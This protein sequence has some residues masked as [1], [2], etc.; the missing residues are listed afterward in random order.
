MAGISTITITSRRSEED[1]DAET[2]P[3][4]MSSSVE[5]DTEED[6]NE[7]ATRVVPISKPSLAK[8][9]EEPVKIR[10]HRLQQLA[11]SSAPK[12]DPV[13]EEPVTIPSHRLQ[14]L[15]PPN[16][17]QTLHTSECSE[18]FSQSTQ[19]QIE[20]A[21]ARGWWCH[22]ELPLQQL[23]LQ[24][25]AKSGTLTNLEYLKL[26]SYEIDLGELELA[27][28]VE[29]DLKMRQRALVDMYYPNRTP[30][31]RSSIASRCREVEVIDST[32]SLQTFVSISRSCG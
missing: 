30:T 31:D 25:K 20:R 4:Q 24:R 19:S 15:A 11:K 17:L 3:P 1:S 28:E 32:G 7:E 13:P 9:S 10:S 18:S 2:D 29:Q 12:F 8:S 14:Q 6:C 22:D 21:L 23:Y 26:K 16:L 27:Q 5:E